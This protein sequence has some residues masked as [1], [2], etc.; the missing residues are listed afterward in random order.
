MPVRIAK[1]EPAATAEEKRE[2]LAMLES[3]GSH[4]AGI[5]SRAV[6]LQVI[7]ANRG[8]AGPPYER[9]IDFLNREMSKAWLGQTLT[10]DI[11]GQS[12]SIAASRVHEVVRQDILADDIRK[13]GRTI[14]RDLL[15]PLTRLRFGPDVPVPFFGRKSKPPTDPS[16]LA[17]VIDLAVNRLGIRVPL[18]WARQSLGIPGGEEDDGFVPGVPDPSPLVRE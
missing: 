8:S 7:E 11:T 2:M 16:E 10:T 17:G 15:A 4:A 9:L 3:L 14:R 5:F 6:D 12:G 13:E 1:Y 18:A